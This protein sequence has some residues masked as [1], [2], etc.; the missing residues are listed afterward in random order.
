MKGVDSLLKGNN[1]ASIE[2]PSLSV[3]RSIYGIA[4]DASVVPDYAPETQASIK[5]TPTKLAEG[6]WIADLIK[7]QNLEGLRWEA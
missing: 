3:W 5:E 1:I 4:S 7:D 2:G 6:L